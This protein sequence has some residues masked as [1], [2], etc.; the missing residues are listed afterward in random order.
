MG[1]FLLVSFSSVVNILTVLSLNVAVAGQDVRIL[2]KR[3]M[4]SVVMVEAKGDDNQTVAIGSGFF[5]EPDVVATNLH[6]LRRCSSAVVRVVGTKKNL[7][8]AGVIGIDTVNDLAL[9]LVEDANVAPLKLSQ[10]V[11]LPVGEKIFAFGNPRGLEGTVS[12]GIVSGLQ[13]RTFGK[14]E[15]IQ[16]TAPISPGSSGGPVVDVQGRVV[17]VATLFFKES[18][19]LN[20]AVPARFLQQ[21]ISFSNERMS[22]APVSQI[23]RLFDDEKSGSKLLNRTNIAERISR[24]LVGTSRRSSLPDGTIVESR[25]A[26]VELSECRIRIVTVSA[27]PT[28]PVKSTEIISFDLSRSSGVALLPGSD[29]KSSREL[30]FIGE[31]ALVEYFLGDQLVRTSRPSPGV[32]FPLSN[33]SQAETI[34][35]D[36][37]SL[38]QMCVDENNSQSREP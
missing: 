22:L 8:V 3:I 2:A 37:E 5:V 17:G 13:T 34:R 1:R 4:P 32:K 31:S 6:I 38:R 29:D 15:F 14:S 16:I 20:F 7:K 27:M 24:S 25:V 23:R 11:R 12:D 33:Q 36:F 26:S 10:A 18:Q 19:N 35:L 30:A 28:T 9:L 21:L